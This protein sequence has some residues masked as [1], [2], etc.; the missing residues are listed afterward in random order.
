VAFVVYFV[1][2]FVGRNAGTYGRWMQINVIMVLVMFDTVLFVIFCT[3]ERNVELECEVRV[4][5]IECQM[6]VIES[7]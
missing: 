5:S 6:E 4:S 3:T 2:Y 7:V 1:G